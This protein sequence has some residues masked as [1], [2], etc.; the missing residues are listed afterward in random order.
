MQVLTPEQIYK[1]NWYK[2]NR[3][4]LLAKAKEWRLNN[5]ERKSANDRAYREAN[6]EK[7]LAKAMEWAAK[8]PE[9]RKAAYT[10]YRIEKID[11][12][13]ANEAAYRAR[14]RDACNERIRQ[15]KAKNPHKLTHYFHK[16]RSAELSA[17]PIWAD[18]DAI[19]S[20]YLEAQR[21]QSET[22][23]PQHVD[24]VVPLISKIVCGLHCEA[25]LRVI[26]ATENM[27]KCNRYWPDM[28]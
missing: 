6:K 26:T 7:C 27:K 23:I 22:G 5:P 4:R 16:R 17:T 25:N 15:W 21:I 12:V 11:R 9:K 19:E 1:Q 18:F 3:D 10:K 8:N 13:R 20:I 2:A 24:H 28:P 14:N